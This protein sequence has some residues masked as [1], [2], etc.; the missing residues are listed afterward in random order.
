MYY[1]RHF[2]EHNNLPSKPKKIGIRIF[3]LNQL[4]QGKGNFKVI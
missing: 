4:V 3:N 1:F 2:M